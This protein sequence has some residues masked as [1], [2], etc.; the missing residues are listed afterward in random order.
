VDYHKK[1]NPNSV[2]MDSSLENLN[3]VKMKSLISP[4]E[5]KAKLPVLPEIAQLIIKT[6]KEIADI[7]HHRSKRKLFVIGPCS[8]HNVEEG[9]EYGKKLKEIS[10]EISDNIL[11]VMRVYFEKPRTTIGWKG[12]IND[13]DL[14]DTCDIN[15]GLYLARKLLIDLNSIGIPCGYEILDTITPQYISDLISWGAIGARTTESQ[16]H[17]QLVS[18][19]SMPV[20]FKNGTGGSKQIAVDG[21]RSA[22]FPHSF[23]GISNTGRAMICYT[24]GNRNCH[25]ILRGG[26]NSTN[27]HDKDIEEVNNLMMKCSIMIDCSHANSNKNYKNQPR[28]FR[29]VFNKFKKYDSIIGVM[30]E[31][32]INEG[33]QKLSDN[34]RYGVSITDSCM[35]FEQTAILLREAMVVLSKEISTMSYV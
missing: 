11:V 24:R 13:P 15:K 5:L 21:I 35:S 18:G 1:L 34:L 32:N 8:I 30:L 23:M 3:I 33:N 22:Q 4:I 19:M 7:I 6:R 14:D 2:Y 10:D 20:G 12:L 27:Y 17:R 29:H 16:V 9:L 31:S 28:V 25:L 26:K